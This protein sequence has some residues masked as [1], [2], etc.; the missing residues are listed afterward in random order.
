M[1]HVVFVHGLDNMPEADYLFNLWKRKLAFEN[2]L[3]LDSCGISASMNYWADVLY[4]SPDTNIA[5]CESATGTIEGVD[6]PPALNR[7]DT[8]TTS[9]FAS[10]P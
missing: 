1:A 10:R 4:E 7:L 9:A 6:V 5:A 2:G 3:D 8:K